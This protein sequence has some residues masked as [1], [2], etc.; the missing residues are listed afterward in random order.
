MAALQR[1]YEGDDTVDDTLLNQISK[2]IFYE[3]LSSLA[4]DLAI[5]QT[6]ISGLV[7]IKTSQEKIFK[8]STFFIEIFF[9]LV[10]KLFIELLRT[11]FL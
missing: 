4:R 10:N 3:N 5:P 2:F 7:E 6:E 8:V 11:V 9:Y 1:I